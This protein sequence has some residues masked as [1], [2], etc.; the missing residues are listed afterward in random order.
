MNFLQNF[1]Q[2]PASEN[3]RNDLQK[4]SGVTGA[5]KPKPEPRRTNQ[6]DAKSA[7]PTPDQLAEALDWLSLY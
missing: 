4:L 6:G 1:F 5:S 7:G 3:G 2:S